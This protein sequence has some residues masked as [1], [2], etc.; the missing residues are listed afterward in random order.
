MDILKKIDLMSSKNPIKKMVHGAQFTY[1]IFV[2][3]SQNY[4]YQIEELVK[5]DPVDVVKVH[6]YVRRLWNT[7]WKRN[8]TREEFDK[9]LYRWIKMVS[10]DKFV[11][12]F[13][14]SIG[15]RNFK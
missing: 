2:N 13:Y 6:H 10:N 15:L 14:H 7:Q 12:N 9:W 5:K 8:I 11:N 1:D 3:N 4:L